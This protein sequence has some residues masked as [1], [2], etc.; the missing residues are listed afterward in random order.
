MT[1]TDARERLTLCVDG[2]V[3]GP[4]WSTEPGLDAVAVGRADLRALLDDHARLAAKAAEARR[5]AM[6]ECL[7]YATSVRGR[8]EP[9]LALSFV[10]SFCETEAEER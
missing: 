3:P 2:P 7:A 10:V 8:Y 6:G 4:E 5:A 1:I 9:A